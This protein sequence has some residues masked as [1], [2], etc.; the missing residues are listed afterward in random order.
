MTLIKPIA[1]ELKHSLIQTKQKIICKICY[2]HLSKTLGELNL[3]IK[4]EKFILSV[5]DVSCKCAEIVILKITR[6]HCKHL[7][8]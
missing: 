3:K 6:T 1:P 8:K 7:D 4:L 2:F 5:M